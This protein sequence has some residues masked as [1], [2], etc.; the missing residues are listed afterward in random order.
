VKQSFSRGAL[1]ALIAWVAMG[2]MLVS[3][4]AEADSIGL[5]IVYDTSGSMGLTVPDSVGKGTP[6]YV[7]ANR[8]FLA[9]VDRLEAF[10][11]EHPAIVLRTSLTVFEKLEARTVVPFGDFQPEQLRAWIRDFSKPEGPTPLGEALRTAGE[12]LVTSKLS[13]RHVLVVT[14]GESNG[15]LSPPNAIIA[16]RNALAP[17]D[18]SLGFHFVAFDVA[19]S[20]FGPVK[21]LGATVLSA[22]NEQQLGVQLATILEKKILL[23]D[24]EPPAKRK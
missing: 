8:A 23:E 3:A 13:R 5:A 20:A 24:E 17:G 21:S 10:H 19:A 1:A 18:V 4:R 6:K 12:P 14:D 2:L 15:K 11:K 7:I 9:I 22:S 16:L